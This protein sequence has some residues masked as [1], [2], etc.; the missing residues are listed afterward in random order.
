M[1]T[2]ENQNTLDRNGIGLIK[3]LIFDFDGLILDTETPLYD[4]WKEI[5]NRYGFDLD[6]SLWSKTLGSSENEFN[7][8]KF[9]E[10]KLN[11]A[12]DENTLRSTVRVNTDRAIL[13]EQP[14]PGIPSTLVQARQMG[15]KLAVASSSTRSWVAGH[16]KRLDLYQFFQTIVCSEDVPYVK[17]APDLFQSALFGLGLNPQE[18]IVFEDSPNG[19]TAARRAGIFSVCIPNGISSQY[20]VSHADLILPQIDAILLT[21]IIHLAEG[22]AIPA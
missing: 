18:A 16:L 21:E 11:R 17:P 22:V 8:G 20:D 13:E 19:I 5:Y 7:P 6:L 14:L 15:L 9:L 4:A 3:G 12:V 2:L 1:S 10:G